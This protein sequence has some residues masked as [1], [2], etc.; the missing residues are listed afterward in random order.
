MRVPSSPLSRDAS[1]GVP[2]SLPGS[3]AAS[4]PS[5]LPMYMSSAGGGNYPPGYGNH[6]V[7]WPDLVFLRPLCTLRLV[8]LSLVKVVLGDT[9]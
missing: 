2:S 5:S 6:A 4:S 7:M 8:C 3:L 1:P 9:Q